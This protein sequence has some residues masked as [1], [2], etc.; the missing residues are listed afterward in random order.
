MSD[1]LCVS[2]CL[3]VTSVTLVL[4]F[5]VA[6][7]EFV[8]RVSVCL[9]VCVCVCDIVGVFVCVGVSFAA[10]SLLCAGCVSDELLMIDGIS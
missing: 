8:T 10:L 7:C 3:R 5:L 9:C 1:C 6:V 2:G 4:A